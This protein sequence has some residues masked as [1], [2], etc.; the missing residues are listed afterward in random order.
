MKKIIFS[1]LSILMALALLVSCGK[2]G[3]TSSEKPIDLTNVSVDSLKTLGDIIAL[4][5][6]D[7]QL[8]CYE[9]CYVYAF[10]LNGTYYRAISNLSEEDSETI[11]DLDILEEDYEKKRNKLISPLKID[12]MENLS[13]QIMTREEMDSWIGKTGQELIDAKWYTNG[14]NL[15]T[16]EFWLGYG[17]FVYTVVF[18]GEVAEKDYEDFDDEE[19]I[20]DFTVK[21]VEYDSIGD[22]TNIETE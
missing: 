10:N 16:M 11:M 12:K 9:Q 8:A 14:H 22:A 3:N 18:D 4:K 2:A 5:I 15:E 21:S 6:E 7:Q 17:P 1:A 13:E 20:K 19:D